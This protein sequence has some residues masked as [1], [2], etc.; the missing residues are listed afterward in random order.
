MALCSK[1]GAEFEGENC[2]ACVPATAPE[3][4]SSGQSSDVIQQA[5]DF[6]RT[7][8]ARFV[9]PGIFALAFLTMFLPFGSFG[10]SGWG[11]SSRFSFS[12]FNWLSSVHGLGNAFITLF[13]ALL[14]LTVLGGIGLSFFKHEKRT[15]GLIGLSG[16]G[17][18]LLILI[19][20]TIT[21]EISSA[22]VSFRPG[23]GFFFMFLL[24]LGAGALNLFFYKEKITFP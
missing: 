22:E 3:G 10:W 1:C 9:T 7:E 23:F 15:E 13:V 5:K 6:L 14:L 17:V 18:V 20:L 21:I 19:A 24:F 4:S 11:I 2:P 8:N 12:A 16:L